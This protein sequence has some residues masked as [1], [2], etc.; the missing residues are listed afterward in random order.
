MAQ[1]DLDDLGAFAA[2]ARHLSFRAAARELGVSASTLSQR[3]RDL[4]DRLGTRLLNRTT[5]SVAPTEA[6]ARLLQRLAPA[7]VEI[8]G[9]LDQLHASEGEVAG[10]LRINA[11]VPAVDLVLAPMLGPFLAAHPRLRLEIV[12]EAALVDIVEAGFDA[13]V[14]WG[15]DLAQDMVAVSLSG[16]QRFAVVAT[17]A[18]IARWGMPER[19]EELQGRPCIRQL[20]P[21]GIRPPWEFERDGRIVRIDAD[22]PLLTTSL[23]AKLRAA[24]DGVGFCATFE[25]YVAE[26]I[27]AGRLVRVLDDWCAPFPGPFLYYPRHR[28]TPAPLRAF[29]DFVR[30]WRR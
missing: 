19:P 17:P 22:G 9:A 3:L 15:E 29:V 11:P 25:D 27:A 4:E 28:H 26:D 18:I 12:T 7:L 10:T 24:C 2:V 14:R 23:A 5:R 16:P 20:F 13:G 6:G 21:G 30:R 8:A 1:V